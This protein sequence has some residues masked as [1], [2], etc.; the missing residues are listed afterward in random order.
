M[1]VEVSMDRAICL[2]EVWEMTGRKP[3]KRGEGQ[4]VLGQASSLPWF[5]WSGFV[6]VG[7]HASQL[8]TQQGDREIPN[9]T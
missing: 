8:T 5:S 6:V 1:A 7:S 9:E 3:R 2:E 4:K